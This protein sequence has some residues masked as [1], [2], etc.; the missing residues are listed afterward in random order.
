M[1]QIF[2]CDADKLEVIVKLANNDEKITTLDYKERKVI[3]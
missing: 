3:N 1:Q 2:F